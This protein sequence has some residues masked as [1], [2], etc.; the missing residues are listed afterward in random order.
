[1]KESEM[2][3]EVKSNKTGILFRLIPSGSFTMGSPSFEDERS[4]DETTHQVMI[5]KGFYCGKY[6]VTQG[7]WKK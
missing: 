3:L 5:T 1:M 6:E 2:P 4:S 7:Q